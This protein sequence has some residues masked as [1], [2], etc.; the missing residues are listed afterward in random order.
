M[1]PDNII[2]IDNARAKNL[3][4][5]YVQ[6]NTKE[7]SIN[8]SFLCAGMKPSVDLD[9][10]LRCQLNILLIPIDYLD[11]SA[12]LNTLT[13]NDTRTCAEGFYLENNSQTSTC[14]PLCDIWISASEISAAQDVIFVISMF[15]AIV[16]SVIL[17]ILALGFQRDTM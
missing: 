13:R 14:T 2:M 6:S 4:I 11:I 10:T 5:H 16:G 1:V 15:V 8:V 3:S 9:T 17:F 7:T 12:C